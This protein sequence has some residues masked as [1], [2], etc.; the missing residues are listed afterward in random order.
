MPEESD[1]GNAAGEW[2][3]L[4]DDSAPTEPAAGDVAIAWPSD[5]EMGVAQ[6]AEDN[7]FAAL[8]GDTEDAL[9]ADMAQ[10]GNASGEESFATM[11]PIHAAKL[12]AHDAGVPDHAHDQDEPPLAQPIEDDQPVDLAA[13]VEEVEVR[14]SRSRKK[15]PWRLRSSRWKRWSI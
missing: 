8:G 12:S 15:F 14:R 3:S 10:V 2:A 6:P 4:D 1:A 5:D 13:V 9:S 7:P 11:P